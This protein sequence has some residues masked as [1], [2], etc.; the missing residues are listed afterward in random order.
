MQQLLPQDIPED[1]SWMR[2][3]PIWRKV[4]EE[5]VTLK[6]ANKMSTFNFPWPTNLAM[7]VLLRSAN[8]VLSHFHLPETEVTILLLQTFM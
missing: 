4:Q 5:I 2:D 6:M 3:N 8:P 1:I 7:M